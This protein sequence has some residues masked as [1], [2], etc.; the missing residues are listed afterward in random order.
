MI[1]RARPKYLTETFLEKEE[2]SFLE[3]NQYSD[4]LFFNQGR[5]ALKFF[6]QQYSNFKKSKINIALQSFNCVMVY[7]SAEEADCNIELFDI[8]LKDFS[9]T[10][11][12]IKNLQVK[13][14]VLILT[15]YQGIPNL[16]YIEIADYCDKND[17]FLI[18][19]LSQ[20][21]GSKIKNIE[22]GKLSNISI[23]SF[24][25]DKP[26]SVYKGGS[27]KFEKFT[28]TF[29]KNY[30]IEAYNKIKFEPKRTSKIH[31]KVLLL[32]MQYSSE[33]KYFKNL[34]NFSLIEFLFFFNFP[35]QI[36][37]LII[38]NKFALKL[39]YSIN[40]FLMFFI[41]NRRNKIKILKIDVE[42]IKL[43]QEQK[44]KFY[45]SIVNSEI[46]YLENF[47]SSNNIEF[48]NYS[49]CKI[50]W[51]RYSI[52]DISGK[53]KNALLPFSDQIEYK[54]F[55]WPE[56]LHKIKITHQNK[57]FTNSEIASKHIINIPVWSNFFKN[58]F[59]K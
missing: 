6:L 51:N 41:K 40:R 58:N 17:I 10:I 37:I 52:I 28:D 23:H 11:E 39:W 9:A 21:E 20:T 4:E 44:T 19:D 55:N 54:N 13:P 33:T 45:K 56:S 3:K 16:N 38:S 48:N 8:N 50:N 35:K 34:N 29:F 1:I 22:V 26:F 27:L 7:N 14:D 59:V 36:I 12:E 24:G 49:E 53:I 31:L 47:L 57:E 15:H 46:K 30:L 5:S 18:D 2:I 32:L 25:F 42:K 43:I